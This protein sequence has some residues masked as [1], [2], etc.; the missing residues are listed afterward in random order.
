MATVAQVKRQSLELLG[1]LRLGQSFQTQDDTAMQ[2]SYDEVYANL[3]ELG[4][5]TW[6]S[7]AAIPAKVVPY[8]VALT[9]FNR[10]D[11]YGVSDSR[12]KRIAAKAVSAPSAI[13]MLTTPPFESLEEPV[14]Y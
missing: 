8:V 7:T 5:A 9:A 12:Y 10:I 2:E 4:L 11:T 3:K 13:R 14:D 6:A 1:R